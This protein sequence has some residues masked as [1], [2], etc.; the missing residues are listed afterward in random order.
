[1]DIFYKSNYIGCGCGF[2][3]TG[4]APFERQ[5]YFLLW[6]TECGCGGWPGGSCHA[7]PEHL[8][9]PQVKVRNSWESIV[10]DVSSKIST[11]WK[12]KTCKINWE[13]IKSLIRLDVSQVKSGSKALWCFCQK[14]RR[15]IASLRIGK[16][17]IVKTSRKLP[18]IKQ[19]IKTFKDSEIW[20]MNL[21]IIACF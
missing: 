2:W 5:G 9:K 13:S 10:P 17:C 14:H 6:Y 8:E 7:E 18:R 19:P 1:M 16:H 21:Y 3:N 12:W 4:D 15:K 20:Q 11:G